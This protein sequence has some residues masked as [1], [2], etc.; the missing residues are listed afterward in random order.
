M[1]TQHSSITDPNIH[2]PKGVSTASLGTVYTAD[3][4]GS[5]T[6]TSSGSDK[7]VLIQSLSDLPTPSSGVITLAS[8]TVYLIDGA[9]DIGANRFSLSDKVTV[10]GLGGQHSSITSSTTGAIFTSSAD[11]HLDSFKLTAPAATVFSCT[12]GGYESAQVSQFT[13]NSCLSVGTFT[14]WYSLFWDKGA[15]VS[16][17]TGM[18]FS[19]TCNILI[20]NLVSFLSGY[21]TAVDLNTATFNT[22]TFNR[23]GF[24]NASATSHID[25]AASSANINSGKTGR[26]ISC[27]F[28]TGATNIVNNFSAG[29]IRWN[30]FHNTNLPNT[31]K[32]AQAYMHVANTTTISGGDGDAGNPKLIDGS[33]DW[34]AYHEDQFTVS[35]AGRLTYIGIEDTEFTVQANVSGT[36]SSSTQTFS[37]YLAKNGTPITASRTEREFSSTAVGSPAPCITIVSLSTND[38]L[39]VYLENNTGTINWDSSILNIV[40]GEG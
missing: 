35:T 11:F 18:S 17:T 24:S 25:I 19:G 28:V 27:S 26:L 30:S 1:T 5:G 39:E 32:N 3:G 37:F 12:G 13:V 8:D 7:E 10:R 21:S 4:V 22:C 40:I 9:I 34:V 36:C 6:W 29:D 2:E 38:Y 14:N 33:T 23:C 31:V 16:T 20:M 15:V